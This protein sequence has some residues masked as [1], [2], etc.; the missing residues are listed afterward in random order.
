MLQWTLIAFRLA[1]LITYKH[2]ICILFCLFGMV[3][4]HYI[5]LEK[6]IEFVHV[7]WKIYWTNLIYSCFHVKM[8][9]IYFILISKEYILSYFGLRDT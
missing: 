6:L 1:W 7:N 2:T 4:I 9:G 3:K 8:L 5:L